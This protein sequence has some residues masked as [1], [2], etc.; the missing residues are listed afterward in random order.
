VTQYRL[1]FEG[2]DVARIKRADDPSG[3]PLAWFRVVYVDASNDVD[4]V[5][6][7]A[8]AEAVGDRPWLASCATI[9]AAVT[10]CDQ[11]HSGSQAGSYDWTGG[12]TETSVAA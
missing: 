9:A 6:V 1:V 12:S 3:A 8:H 10:Y 11:L 5:H 2:T 4:T 7:Y